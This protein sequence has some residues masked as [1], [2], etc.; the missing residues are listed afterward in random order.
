[1]NKLLA[2]IARD[3]AVKFYHGFVMHTKPNFQDLI[4]PF[5]ISEQQA[6]RTWCGAFVHYCCKKAGF[7][8]P[9][10]PPGSSFDFLKC[11]AW[12]DWAKADKNIDYFKA[13]NNGSTPE[14]GDIVLYDKVFDNRENDHIGIIVDLNGDTITA[15]EGNINNVSGIISRQ[16]DHHIRAY[17]RIPE[18]YSYKAD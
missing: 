11:Y 14:I 8:L 18:N 10:K 13:G 3:E 4:R 2:K 15:A 17:I 16:I 9:A 6:D 5:G 7:N 12:E 1:M